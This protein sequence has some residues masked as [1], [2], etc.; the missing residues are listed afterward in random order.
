MSKYTTGEMAKLCNISVRAVQFYDA[1]GLLPPSELSEGGR[2]IYTDDDLT[3]LRL[4]CMLKE[5]GLSLSSIQ[6]ILS[7]EAPA[8]V[9]N[10]LLDEHAKLVNDEIEEKKK[11]LAAIKI[12]K[13]SIRNMNAIPINSINDIASIMKNE[14]GLKKLRGIMLGFGII[15]GPFQWGSIFLWIVKGLWV[16]FAVVYSI[17]II[18]SIPLTINYYKSTKY[19]CPECNA[20][21]RPK[22]KNFFFSKHTSKT[23]KLK[24]EECGHKGYCVEVYAKDNEKS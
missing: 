18:L 8:K 7:S 22:F 6:G 12:V 5:L 1:K 9:L 4:I 2:R 11:Q 17:A 19:I 3:K 20:V 13:E 23:R 15:I 14:K 10:L 24:C 16:P 21:F